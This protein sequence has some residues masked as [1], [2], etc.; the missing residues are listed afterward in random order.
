MG[1]DMC[2]GLTCINNSTGGAGYGGPWNGA[3]SGGWGGG[4]YSGGGGLG[5]GG[6]LATYRCGVD[7]FCIQKGGI[8]P[9]NDPVANGGSWNN[10]SVAGGYIWQYGAKHYSSPDCPPGIICGGV[11]EGWFVTGTVGS[12]NNS[13]LPIVAGGVLPPNDATS[14]ALKYLTRGRPPVTPGPEPIFKPTPGP[15]PGDLSIDRIPTN[16]ANPDTLWKLRYA[17]AQAL[18]I[19]QNYRPTLVIMAD[20]CAYRSL[21]ASCNKRSD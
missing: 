4:D 3:P 14:I 1:L 13:W 9:L 15:S 6:T 12:T 16:P 8:A 5:G 21:S 11:Q 20:P 2:L 18:R 7:P 10:T 19:F 17:I